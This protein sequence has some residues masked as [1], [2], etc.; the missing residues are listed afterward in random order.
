MPAHALGESRRNMRRKCGRDDVRKWLTRHWESGPACS[1]SLK[2]IIFAPNGS[3]LGLDRKEGLGERG[4]GSRTPALRGSAASGERG[5]ERRATD[6]SSAGRAVE[7][8]GTPVRR[9]PLAGGRT[10]AWFASGT[11]KPGLVMVFGGLSHLGAE[12]D[13]DVAWFCRRLAEHC[14]LIRYDPPGS[15]LGDREEWDFSLDGQVETLAS[16]I[17]ACGERRVALLGYGLGSFC[18]L[19]YAVAHPERVAHLVLFNAAARLTRSP[20]YPDGGDP[21]TV[22]ALEDLVRADW[23][24]GS[25]ALARFLEPG[26]TSDAVDRLAAAWR[27]S[28]SA[29]AAADFLRHTSGFDVRTLLGRLATPTLVLHRREQ[30]FTVHHAYRLTEGIRG[31]ELR[32]LDGGGHFP[33]HGARAAVARLVTDFVGRK[34]LP[35]TG[36]EMEIMHAVAAGLSNRDIGH[37]LGITSSTVA[38]HLANVFLKLNVSSR[39]AALAELRAAGAFEAAGADLEAVVAAGDDDDDVE[40]RVMP[41][42][43][44]MKAS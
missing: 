22:T 14:R 7:I 18:A 8:W 36:R 26:A 3:G 24:L 5:S 1:S 25:Y 13:D 21:A 11:G 31:A 38:R 16:V 33:W 39:V 27:S 28:M 10:A 44:R 42:D 4:W 30:S 29:R 43:T 32:L 37:L 6:M 41:A 23:T 15:G 35:L 20:D 40:R 19:A 9:V 34:P 2:L 12:L 17:H